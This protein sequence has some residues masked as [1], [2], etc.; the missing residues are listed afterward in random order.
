MNDRIYNFRDMK[1][2]G[3]L[4]ILSLIINV[5]F[6]QQADQIQRGQRGYSP[7]ILYNNSTFIALVNPQEEL[8]KIM[9][10][11][12]SEFNLDAFEQEIIKAMF[13]KKFESHNAI[14]E[15]EKNTRTLRKKKL[16]NLDKEFLKELGTMLSPEEVEKYKTMDFTETKEERKERKK[17]EKKKRKN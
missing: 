5:G 11:C 14:L 16:D 1:K 7:P 2:F 13:V 15:D 12:I 10:K 9:P 6:A 3:L 4:L 8:D 17:R